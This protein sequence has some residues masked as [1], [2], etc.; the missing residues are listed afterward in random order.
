[1][2]KIVLSIAAISISIMLFAQAP[3]S[4][5]FQSIVKDADGELVKS[6]S[7]GLQISILATAIDGSAVYTETHTVSTNSNGLL[8]IEIGTGTSSDDFSAINWAS[9]N[10]FVK[11]EVDLDGGSSYTISGTSQ[12]L[13]VPYALHANTVETIPTNYS[14]LSVE[15]TLSVGANGVP[16]TSIVKMS[17]TTDATENYVFVDFPEGYSNNNCFVLSLQVFYAP[18]MNSSSYC[19]LGY[20]GTNGTLSYELSYFMDFLSGVIT[21]TLKVNYPDELKGKD[22][23]VILMKYK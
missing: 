10:Y 22:F 4:F 5:S 18:Y 20:T 9:D 13:S 3:Q 21:R 1:M 16:I 23:S 12:L 15:D 14:K 11:T 2:K 17:G 19:G 7:V 6:Q 8:T